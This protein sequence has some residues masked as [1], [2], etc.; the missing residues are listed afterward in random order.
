[1]RP[2]VS[3]SSMLVGHM[4][5][6][7]LLSCYKSDTHPSSI[8]HPSSVT[9][10]SSITHP[11]SVTQPSPFSSLSGSLESLTSQPEHRDSDRDSGQGYSIPSS[12]RSSTSSEVLGATLDT[13][14]PSSPTPL[15]PASGARSIQ[16]TE[17][18]KHAG[19]RAILVDAVSPCVYRCK[20]CGRVRGRH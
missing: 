6:S 11:S 5:L 4:Q 2:P 13:Y 12:L 19:S 15:Y 14:P 20:H 8:T 17:P 10:P 3:S 1:M 9:H 16:S 18:L 7:S